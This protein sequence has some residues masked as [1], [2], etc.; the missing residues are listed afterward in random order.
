[1]TEQNKPEDEETIVDSKTAGKVSAA[2]HFWVNAARGAYLV[3][4]G[5]TSKRGSRFL[6]LVV[7]SLSAFFIWSQLSQQTSLTRAANSQALVNLVGPMNM[8]LV[9]NAEIAELWQRHSRRS[10]KPLE[11][12]EVEEQQ[13]AGLLAT[14]LIFYENMY[15]QHERKLLDDDVFDGWEKD[16]EDLVESQPLEE[17]WDTDQKNYY[18]PAFSNHVARLLEAKRAGQSNSVH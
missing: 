15:I 3:W 6:Q 18:V 16:L 7:V 11:K 1:M 12:T 17:Y 13:Y 2:S 8:E 14:Y 10:E 9:R 4:R 5:I